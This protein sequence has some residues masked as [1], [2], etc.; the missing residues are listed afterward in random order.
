MTTHEIVV[1]VEDKWFDLEIDNDKNPLAIVLSAG[2]SAY[3]WEYLG[4]ELRGRQTY[5]VKLVRLGYVCNVERARRKANALGYRL[6]GGHARE[7]FKAKFPNNDRKGPVIFGAS[8]W[9]D[10]YD[11]VVVASLD[12]F[13][14]GWNE[15][16]S[17]SGGYFGKAC[18]WLVVSKQLSNI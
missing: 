18:R 4:P 7:P 10:S 16:F 14:G 3:N 15:S 17:V 5:Q 8:E 13:E 12:G 2:H 1:P 6:V 11:E 9:K